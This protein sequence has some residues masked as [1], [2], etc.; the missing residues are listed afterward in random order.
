MAIAPELLRPQPEDEIE[1]P[2]GDGEPMAETDLHRQLML[3]TI[4]ALQ[5]HFADQ[6]EVYVSGDNFIYY[7]EKDNQT[8]VSPDCYVVFEVGNGPRDAYFVWEEMGRM[9]DV[10][11][12][13]TSKSTREEDTDHKFQVYEQRLGVKEYFLFD[14]T[15]DYLSPILQG[16]RLEKKRYVSIPLEGDRMFSRQLG[17]E[18]VIQGETLRLYNPITGEWL[19][20]PEGQRERADFAEQRADAAEQRAEA[21]AQALLEAEARVAQ[22]MA[23]LEALRSKE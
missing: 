11:F 19:L 10:V 2:T 21:T 12:E 5:T 3:D 17:L 7:V 22:L 6:P 20:T 4:F 8:R 18:L 16:H 14:P 9:P 15:G 23:E 13:F 1:Y